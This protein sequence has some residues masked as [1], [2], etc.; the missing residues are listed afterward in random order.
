[1]REIVGQL[2]SLLQAYGYR[3]E[4][5]RER[6]A[7]EDVGALARVPQLIV[8]GQ[9]RAITESD[10]TQNQP[11]FVVVEDNPPAGQLERITAV[12]HL[13]ESAPEILSFSR[14]IDRLWHADVASQWAQRDS[15]SAEDTSLP[16]GMSRPER[17]QPIDRYADQ[18]LEIEHRKLPAL[19]YALDWLSAEENSVLVI[20]AE[21]GLGKSEFTRVLQ[22]R[23]AIDYANHFTK[24]M[25][26]G[27]P[28]VLLR[29]RL[30]NLGSLALDAIV[31]YMRTTVGLDRVP[32]AQ[33]LTHLLQCGRLTLLLDGL[34]ELDAPR[35]EIVYGLEELEQLSQSGGHVL[36]TSRAGFARTEAP[37]RTALHAA[38]IS[39]LQ[40]LAESGAIEMLEKHGARQTSARTVYR[41]LPD[42]IRGVPLFLLWGHLSGHMGGREN[43]NAETL[44]DMIHQFCQREE[45]RLLLSAAEQ[46]KLLGEVAYYST[47]G[48]LSVD[49]AIIL[50]GDE[51]SRFVQGPH[52][53]LQLEPGN[54]LQFRYA[55][56]AD[57]FLASGVISNW[58]EASHAGPVR[59]RSWLQDRLGDRALQPL[60]CEFLTDFIE[61]GQLT[62]AWLAA[63][64]APLRYHPWVRRNILALAIEA[65]GRHPGAQEPGPRAQILEKLLGNRDLASCVVA[66][67][68]L[69][70]FDFRDW[71]LRGLNGS[72]ACFAFCNFAGARLDEGLY[73]AQL[74]SC[75]GL[76][77][78]AQEHERLKR[79]QQA[80]QRALRPFQNRAL[81]RHALH[82]RIAH[83]TPGL[84]LKAVELLRR[85]G[86]V[87]KE[88][89]ER[90]SFSLVLTD[91][92]R[93]EL[94]EFL[95]NPTRKTSVALAKLLEEMG[96]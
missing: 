28:T 61:D 23:A 16:A 89:R 92:G 22:W 53:L 6:V 46:M 56:F 39:E 2:D 77:R 11:N 70:M 60:A 29:V 37:I 90:G 76:P 95:E 82:P 43:N 15:E 67:L 34:D 84:D 36:L 88:Q 91:R 31:E 32:N 13:T 54:L 57:L 21:A 14:F 1:M 71:D 55:P 41:A 25:T 5:R 59:L 96:A 80:L 47:A 19:T 78:R 9:A 27:L 58:R 38:T 79:G 24:G 69:E 10:I 30:R 48:S 50:C 74:E 63:S 49:D 40:P 83:N 64:Q 44:L 72:S 62:E 35:S 17:A 86:F 45:A 18:H 73:S 3:T 7:F 87:I 8:A 65:V 68:T 12:G 51:N 85:H 20:L 93:L 52:A 81:S 94:Q 66:G 26:V 42:R 33:V 75:K 4:A